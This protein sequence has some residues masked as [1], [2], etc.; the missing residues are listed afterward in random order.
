MDPALGVAFFWL[1]FGG[2]HVGL[3]TRRVRA[4]LVARLG[5]WGTIG[6]FSLIAS[7]TFSALVGY[8]ASH[9]FEGAPGIAA[10]GS[11]PVRGLLITCIVSGLTFALA[12]LWSYPA[13][14][15]ALGNERTREPRG[16][17]RVSRHPF[18]VGVALAGTAHALLATRLAGTVFF[19]GLVLLAVGGAAHQDRKLLAARGAPY[20]HWIA[21]TS[22]LP[23]GAIISGRQRLVWHELPWMAVAMAL[24]AAYALRAVHASILAHGGGWV[25][26]TF[27]GGAAIL[28]LQSWRR[29][30]RASRVLHTATR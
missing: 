30:A 9:R 22:T 13:S 14:P 11:A 15:Y 3:A 16:L 20:A 28:A 24:V 2:T 17:E 6:V 1:L 8:Y 19:A 7:V 5:E 26:A 18:F 12:S 21:V 29:T 25:I 10:G 4:A 23:F 27:V